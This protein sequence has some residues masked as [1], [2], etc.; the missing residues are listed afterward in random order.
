MKHRVMGVSYAQQA[1]VP[2]HTDN[3]LKILSVQKEQHIS[4]LIINITFRY[5]NE[6]L[7]PEH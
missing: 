5:K 1:K 4:N 2:I 7:K 6:A 3:N